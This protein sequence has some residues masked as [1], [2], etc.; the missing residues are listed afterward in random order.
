MWGT[1]FSDK[2]KPTRTRKYRQE[3]SWSLQC[4]FPFL[5]ANF[6]CPCSAVI[7][8][9]WLGLPGLPGH[10]K[11]LMA[12]IPGVP[13]GT[14]PYL[15]THPIG[16]QPAPRSR[17]ER[18]DRRLRPGG[19]SRKA[20]GRGRSWRIFKS[21]KGPNMGMDQYLL[22]A[23]L[24]GWTS[25]YQLFWCSPGVLLVLTHCHMKSVDSL[26]SLDPQLQDRFSQWGPLE[27]VITGHFDCNLLLVQS[28]VTLRHQRVGGHWSKQAS[29]TYWWTQ[30]ELVACMVEEKWLEPATFLSLLT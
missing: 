17:D 25:I 16:L 11:I 4:S 3:I 28:R 9:P 8:I 6:L 24:V 5:S 26:N 15:V 12:K 1:P 21:E 7:F 19:R 18:L 23:F 2:P 22:I 29:L 27:A 13:L 20:Y 14:D 30:I 10:G